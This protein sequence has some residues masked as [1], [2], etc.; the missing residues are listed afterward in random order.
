MPAEPQG[1]PAPRLGVSLTVRLSESER[2]TAEFL[3]KRAGLSIGRFLASLL[4]QAGREEIPKISA[5]VDAV[6]KKFDFRPRRRRR[7]QPR[8]SDLFARFKAPYLRRAHAEPFERAVRNTAKHSHASEFSV[9]RLLSFFAE[10]VAQEVAEGH[11]FRFPGFFVV[12]PWLVERGIHEGR[13]LPRFQASPAFNDYVL[14]NC[15]ARQSRNKELQAHRRRRRRRPSNLTT[16]ME[17]FRARVEAQDRRL[18]DSFE[19]WREFHP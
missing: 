16:A 12:G 5:D 18:L 1:Y 10:A 13:C 7:R 17:G 11:V 6:R 4:H 2:W 14:L 3:A 19:A 8:N 9:A 15:T